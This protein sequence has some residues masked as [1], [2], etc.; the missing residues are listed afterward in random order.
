[1]DPKEKQKLYVLFGIFGMAFLMIYFNLLLKP[2]FAR[3]MARNREYGTVYS[4]V[5]KTQ[6]LIANEQRLRKQN[7]NLKEQFSGMEGKFLGEDE[8]SSLLQSFS[9]I[10]DSSNVQILRIKPLETIGRAAATEST[11]E[12]Y[13]EFPI[14][15]EAKAGYHECGDF[16][17][18]LERAERFI[19]IGDIDIRG[20]QEKPR[21]HEIR[22]RVVTYVLNDR[23]G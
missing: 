21:V 20:S 10:A 11:D 6:A 19:R 3:F 1:M 5:K 23:Q 13:S 17:N 16:L 14:L 7:E 9:E 8:V 12:F 2:Q 15:I 4:R 22:L 18:K